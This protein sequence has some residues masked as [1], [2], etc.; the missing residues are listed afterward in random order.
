MKLLVGFVGFLDETN[1]FLMENFIE[2]F[3]S[4]WD[5]G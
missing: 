2:K 5:K 3:L 1:K 4:K